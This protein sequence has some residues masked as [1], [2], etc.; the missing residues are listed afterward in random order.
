MLRRLNSRRYHHLATRSRNSFVDRSITLRLLV[1][2]GFPPAATLRIIL[3]VHD[4]ALPNPL[5]YVQV[6]LFVHLHVMCEFRLQILNNTGEVVHHAD[7]FGEGGV[8]FL[9]FQLFVD[10]HHLV[11]KEFFDRLGLP[12]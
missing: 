5:I 10:S 3:I 7:A 6:V 2:I 1:F 9:W 12:D 11:F 8:V 4:V